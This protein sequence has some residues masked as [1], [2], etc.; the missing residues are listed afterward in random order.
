M[1]GLDSETY[2]LARNVRLSFLPL[3]QTTDMML[4]RGELDA[5]F[6]PMTEEGVTADNPSVLDRYGGTQMTNNP[7]IHKLLDDSGEAL[8]FEFFRRTGCHQPNHHVIIKNGVLAEHPWVA[9]E[10]VDAFRRSKEAAYEGARKARGTYL[11]FEQEYRRKQAA[12]FGEDPYPLGIKAMRRTLERAIAGSLDQG[13]IRKP[14][15]L[16]DLYFRTTLDT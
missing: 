2:G 1:L 12:V 6:P 14:I 7:G 15:A 13:L 9:M 10:L 3:G 5:A 16:E 8:I 4:D 11:I